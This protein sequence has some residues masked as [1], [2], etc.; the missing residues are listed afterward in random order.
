MIRGRSESLAEAV[1]RQPQLKT[2]A[3]EDPLVDK[4]RDRGD[5]RKLIE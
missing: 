2:Q 4:P 3:A 1:S 5:F